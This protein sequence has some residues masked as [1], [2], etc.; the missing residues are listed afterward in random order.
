MHSHTRPRVPVARR[1]TARRVLACLFALC[2]FDPFTHAQTSPHTLTLPGTL[3]ALN[4]SNGQVLW[5]KPNP[6][7]GCDGK[8]GRPLCRLALPA[9]TT[10]IPGVVFQGSWDG[11]LRAH[12]SRNGNILWQFDTYRPYAGA[13]GFAG[14]GGSINGAGAVVVGDT[15]YVNS[16]YSAFGPGTSLAGN[17]L[18]AFS[19]DG[20]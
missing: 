19:L 3:F 1:R 6:A 18:L 7:D 13:N 5:S 15:V 17:V 16:G 11:H 4:P 12:D 10:T 8:P 14:Q 2:A 9:A 20:N